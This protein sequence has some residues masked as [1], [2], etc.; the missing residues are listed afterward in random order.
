MG[1]PVVFGIRKAFKA[2]ILLVILVLAAMIPGCGGSSMAG[3]TKYSYEF[4]GAF[5]T[6]IQIIGFAKSQ[7]EFEA[8]A[9]LGETR[10]MEL[11]RLF[12]I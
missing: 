5:D 11:H 8:M 9:K 7:D 3:Y 6:V 1:E 4:L 2:I 10:F 12:D